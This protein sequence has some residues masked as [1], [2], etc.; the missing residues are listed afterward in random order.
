M[1]NELN[2]VT[3]LP[4]DLQGNDI[5]FYFLFWLLALCCLLKQPELCCQSGRLPAEGAM[6]HRVSVPSDP[7]I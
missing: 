6:E 1:V 3:S 7:A 2:T 4:L 5:D